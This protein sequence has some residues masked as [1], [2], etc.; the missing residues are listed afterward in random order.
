MGA[1][2]LDAIY[3]RLSTHRPQPSYIPPVLTPLFATRCRQVLQGGAAPT[4]PPQPAD[5]GSVQQTTFRIGGMHCESCAAAVRAALVAAPG[6]VD[7]AV[8]KKTDSAHV[9]FSAAATSIAALA[10]VVD[11]CGFEVLGVESPGAAVAE[12]DG[13]G[14]S[15]QNAERSSLTANVASVRERLKSA[16]GSDGGAGAGGT[17][18]AGPSSFSPARAAASPNKRAKEALET[19]EIKVEVEGMTCDYCKGWLTSALEKLDGVQRVE[20]SLT[21]RTAT[22]F[23][24]MTLAAL[25]D[26]IVRTGYRV[27]GHARQ[28]S[29]QGDGGNTSR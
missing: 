8:A 28:S 17:N 6:V 10:E 29:A 27:P 25:V 20:V 1:E 26:T 12:A 14:G 23:G 16:A 5:A 3:G 24:T 2:R 15:H 4:S 21:T 19:Q 7:A 18:A 9:R 22:V 13:N 11:D